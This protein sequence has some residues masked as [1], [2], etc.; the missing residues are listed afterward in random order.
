MTKHV[1]V[2]W[3]IF[4]ML[5]SGCGYA[6]SSLTQREDVRAFIDKMVVQHGFSREDLI[7]LFK[8]ARI[9]DGIIRAMTR[10]AESKPWHVYRSLFI[11]ERQIDAG[12]E[13]WLA[14]ASSL[15]EAERQY[16]VPAEIIVAILG[17]ETRYGD[18]AGSF[19]IVDALSTLAFDYPKRGAFFTGE[20]E[21]FLLLCRE[22]K[23]DPLEPVGS[24]AGAMGI[25][26]FMPSSFRTFAKDQD[27]DGRRDI[28]HN[29]RDAIA[30]VANYFSEHG[31]IKDGP[32]TFPAIIQGNRF[33]SL[34]GSGLK[35]DTSVSRMQSAGINIPAGID[36]NQEAKL[37][38]LDNEYGPSYWV[39]LANFYVIT[40]YN[41]SAL[42]AM[43]VYQLSR[44]ILHRKEYRA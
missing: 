13:F 11:S 7:E 5:L 22:E 34:L 39:T 41:H 36:V 24:Y 35:P 15:A 29:N 8:N 2:Y 32:V 28:W 38:Q 42:Y 21:Q 23:M 14:N 12:V 43:A 6:S 9:K 17:V 40:R 44:E 20:L 18:N 10:P 1:A 31:W 4:S 25:P 26:Q 27:S 3:V 33:R 16:G 19:R 30:S 37:L